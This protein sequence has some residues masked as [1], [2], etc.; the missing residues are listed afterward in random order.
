MSQVL[1]VARARVRTGAAARLLAEV[2]PFVAASRAEPGCVEYDIYLSAT[3]Y[4]EIASVER[5]ASAEAAA[6]HLAAPH[7]AA[8]LAAVGN[9]LATA[10]VIRQVT[11]EVG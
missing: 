7:T 11:L 5:W 6:A 2:P 1:V 8:F 3:E 10:P 4:E 9:C